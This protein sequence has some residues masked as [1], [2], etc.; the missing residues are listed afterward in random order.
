MNAITRLQDVLEALDGYIVKKVKDDHYTVTKASGDV[1]NL[2]KKGTKWQCDCTGFKYRGACKHV[3]LVGEKI[4]V[5]HPRKLLDDLMPQ[6]KD[7]FKAYKKWEV[8]GSYRRKK[9]DWKD[10]DILVECDKAQFIKIVDV[11]EQDTGYVRTMAGPDII[12]GTYKGYD[13]DVNRCEPGEW[14]AHLLYRTGPKELNLKMRGLAKSKGWKLNE[15]GLFDEN[16]Q[17][18]ARD[19]EEDIFKA[20]GMPYLDPWKR[21]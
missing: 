20:L 21:A 19:T 4:P 12:R 9:S 10:I 2:F 18:L 7:M 17:L 11:L 6:I 5:R 16:S 14:G 3:P 1:Y 8:V 13:F 15:H